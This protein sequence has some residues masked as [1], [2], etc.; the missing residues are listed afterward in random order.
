MKRFAVFVL[1]LLLRIDPTAAAAVAHQAVVHVANGDCAALEQALNLGTQTASGVETGPV[2]E[3]IVLA[4]NGGYPNCFGLNTFGNP[5]SSG[6]VTI[7]GNGSTLSL[8]GQVD[9]HGANVTTNALDIAGSPIT[10]RNIVL[11]IYP[12]PFVPGAHHG[13]S[14]VYIDSFRNDGDLIIESS[15]ILTEPGSGS[16]TNLGTLVLRNVTVIE[17]P[18]SSLPPKPFFGF[19][20]TAP[21]NTVPNAR[22]GTVQIE[23]STLL[24]PGS[25]YY[26][27]FGSGNITVANSILVSGNGELC[28]YVA[29]GLG[30]SVMS[31]GG[32]VLSDKTCGFSAASDRVVNDAGLADFGLHGGVVGT[33]GLRYDSPAKG[34]GL[35]SNCA[36]S[37]ARGV[38]RG[39]SRCD[40][41]AYEFGGGEG[42]LNA[43]GTSGLYY[44]AAHDGH[45][46]TVQK[47]DSGGALVIW[48]TFN[49]NG[50][51]AWLYGVGE[52]NDNTIHVASVSQN[53]DGKLQPGGAV[54]GSHETTW[55][56]FDF[57]TSDCIS[58]SLKYL[59]N[60][61]GFGSGTV[62]LTRLALVNGLDCSP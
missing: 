21:S 38:A 11:D 19:V 45:Y 56:S 62:A 3:L 58:A 55:G 41:G 9:S 33:L 14:G 15:T 16:I 32:N 24:L 42:K 51:P 10:I 28:N 17:K 4:K 47:L 60:N 40:A 5:I 52:V 48:N 54:V 59:S 25:P 18:A 37:D 27:V 34:A 35:A 23:Q 1:C 53:L 36:A 46:V 44:D 49:T 2:G 31:L 7:D 6:A 30:G 22:L 26:A 57:T 61:A 12:D 39:Q 50:M 29:Y 13:G 8:G 20:F 43:S